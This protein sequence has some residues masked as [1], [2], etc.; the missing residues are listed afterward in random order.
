MNEEEMS[1]GEIRAYDE[2]V[3][4]EKEGNLVSWE[5]FKKELETLHRK[6]T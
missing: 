1:A 2:S 5:D 4:N 6:T 3:I